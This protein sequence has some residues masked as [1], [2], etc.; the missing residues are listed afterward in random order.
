[1]EAFNWIKFSRGFLKS[2]INLLNCPIWLEHLVL[3]KKELS[4]TVDFK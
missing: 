4:V 2:W 1:M 3:L